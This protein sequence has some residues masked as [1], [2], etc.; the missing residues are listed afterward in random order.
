MPARDVFICYS[1]PDHEAAHELVGRLEANGVQCWIA[2]R[3]VDPGEDFAAAIVRAIYKARVMVLVFSASSSS[4]P[5]VRREV[6]VAVG[7]DVRYSNASDSRQVRREI[8]LAIDRGVRVVPFRIEDVA[9][10]ATFPFLSGQHCVDAFSP[11]MEP[12]Y[13]K[14]CAYLKTILATPTDPQAM[15]GLAPLWSVGRRPNKVGRP[16]SIDAANL[17]HGRTQ[18]GDPHE[19]LGAI[20]IGTPSGVARIELH[21][22]DLT[23][24]TLEDAVDVLVIS[25]FPNDYTPTPSSL[26]GALHRKGISVEALARSKYLDLR[27]AFSCW[28]STEIAPDIA[29]INFKR[30]LC[31]E[32]LYKEGVDAPEA[33]GDIFRALAPFIGADPHVSSVAMPLPATGNQMYTVAEILPPLLKS[34]VEWLK[35]G[36]PLRTVKIY[37]R[38]HQAAAAQQIL[39]AMSAELQCRP[40]LKPAVRSYDAFISYA[41]TDREAAIAITGHLESAGLRVFV[42]ELHLDT[43]VAWQQEIFRV[44]DQAHAIIALYSPDYVKSKVCQEEFN[45]AWA[46]KRKDADMFVYPIY[47][48]SSELPTYMELL[49]FA[50]CRECRTERLEQACVTLRGKLQGR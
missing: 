27:Q 5:N 4:S 34:A 14:L 21:R 6:M 32:P 7:Q 43:G 38:D 8:T 28:L 46:R 37:V 12:H 44:L 40:E 11:P 48:R 22:G 24:T 41:H 50:D 23:Q 16:E 42:D 15:P 20:E 17:E 30:I 26:I 31:F 10:S 45:I 2:P 29:G 19:V 39:E 25:S 47:W 13:A 49:N 18:S 33:I 3:N 36:L 1:Q 9:L 35:I